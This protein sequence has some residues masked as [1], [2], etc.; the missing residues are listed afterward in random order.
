MILHLTHLLRRGRIYHFRRV[1]PPALRPWFGCSEIRWSLHTEDMDEACRRGTPVARFLSEAFN[2]AMRGEA[3]MPR[4]NDLPA[5]IHTVA[6]AFEKALSREWNQ[7]ILSAGPLSVDTGIRLGEEIGQEIG[8]STE[9]V[10]HKDCGEINN[11]LVR[12]TGTDCDLNGIFP[13]NSPA[14]HGLCQEA[15]NR[16]LR[17]LEGLRRWLRREDQ[18]A[19]LDATAV[20]AL[21]VAPNNQGTTRA[22]PTSAATGI[23][24][25]AAIKAYCDEHTKSG[26]WSGRST[27]KEYQVA[28]QLF[29]DHFGDRPLTEFTHAMLHSFR[30]DV[31]MRLPSNREK[32]EDYRKKPLA[33][34][35]KMEIP[36]G[37]RME[38]NTVNKY[39]RRVNGLFNWA[40]KH[41]E[42]PRSPGHDL[43]LARTKSAHEERSAFSSSDLNAMWTALGELPAR[44][45]WQYWTP[46]VALF[47][48]MRQNEIGQ[49]LLADVI[50]SEKVPCFNVTAEGEDKKLKSLAARRLIPIHP[51]LIKLG[52]L[53][54][55]EARRR[56]K[57][58]RLWS[59]LPLRRDGYGQQISR[60]FA[61]WKKK[62]LSATDSGAK[63]DFHS[64]RHT[65]A[66]GLKQADGRGRVDAG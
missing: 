51:A 22:T 65:F 12:L 1:V 29:L 57:E 13:L 54:Y 30:N 18:G 41:E 2:R 3:P 45:A 64:F 56:R 8:R 33:E 28:L 58:T 40:V 52:F 39:M 6:D 25:D 24:L 4:H 61:L 7:R 66:D 5:F 42:I 55:V 23:R 9:Q 11:L 37:D 62:W 43:Q 44:H 63:K 47:S 19:S 35:L 59:D 32:K 26:Q 14:R 27:I 20:P 50:E 36:D 31:V 53:D 17:V 49:M 60:W 46:L 34:L 16:R 21:V 38:L 48:G 10:A 15:Q